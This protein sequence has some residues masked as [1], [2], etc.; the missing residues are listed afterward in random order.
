M[1]TVQVPRIVH[2]LFVVGLGACAASAQRSLASAPELSLRL[3][4]DSTRVERRGSVITATVQ[5]MAR[6][7][8]DKTVYGVDKCGRSPCYYVQRRDMD[9]SGKDYWREVFVGEWGT[10][11][12]PRTLAPGASSVFVSL[13]TQA[14]GQQPQFAF[15]ES[16]DLYRFVYV[17]STFQIPGSPEIRV[18]S[19]S[20][21]LRRPK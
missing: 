11:N 16:G 6:N 1:E 12:Q 2:C 5:F 17:L 18:I 10:D 15:S 3:L 19:P 7:S 9:A 4:E 8:F 14:P 21:V 13:I 20:V